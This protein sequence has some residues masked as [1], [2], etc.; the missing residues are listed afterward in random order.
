[1]LLKKI[2][3]KFKKEEETPLVIKQAS[4]KPGS[5][6]LPIITRGYY[7]TNQNTY[8]ADLVSI[9][10]RIVHNGGRKVLYPTVFK[11]LKEVAIQYREQGT[12]PIG[13]LF[14]GHFDI[15]QW[16]RGL[17]EYTMRKLADRDSRTFI[18]QK[19]DSFKPTARTTR[20]LVGETDSL[21][22]YLVD[23][24]PGHWLKLQWAESFNDSGE[25][26]WSKEL[27]IH[28]CG[29]L[30]GG[31]LEATANDILK[32][33]NS[34]LF[35]AIAKREEN[36][37]K[38]SKERAKE[39]KKVIEE[40]QEEVIVF[41]KVLYTFWEAV[42]AEFP[43]ITPA[44]EG[45]GKLAEAWI[46]QEIK[47]GKGIVSN[48]D[49]IN[50]ISPEIYNWINGAYY[51]GFFEVYAHGIIDRPVYE[52]DI[53]SAY[54]SV[55]TELPSLEDCK[56]LYFSED[57][58]DKPSRKELDDYVSRG[59]LVFAGIA[60]LSANTN[61]RVA[62]FPFRLNDQRIIRPRYTEYSK[63]YWKE[64]MYAQKAG[65]LF[66]YEENGVTYPWEIKDVTIILPKDPSNKPLAGLAELYEKRIREGKS[67]VLG[68]VRKTTGNSVYGKMTQSI[69]MPKYAN[70]VIAA[71]TTAEV[72]CKI[73]E[74]IASH[75]DGVNSLVQVATDALF[76]D[77][78]HTG[79]DLTPNKLGAW[80]EV[81]FPNFW[82]TQSGFYG[83]LKGEKDVEDELF[84]HFGETL[85]S[86]GITPK[87]LIEARLTTRDDNGENLLDILW[88][89]REE[90]TWDS[91]IRIPIPKQLSMKSIK[92]ALQEGKFE[93][94]G[95][96]VVGHNGLTEDEAFITTAIG[97]KRTH[98]VWVEEKQWFSGNSPE[99]I[100]YSLINRGNFDSTN[101]EEIIGGLLLDGIGAPAPSFMKLEVEEYGGMTPEE[102]NMTLIMDGAIDPFDEDIVNSMRDYEPYKE[103]INSLKGGDSFED[104]EE[105]EDSLEEYSEKEPE[106]DLEEDE[107]DEGDED[108]S[109]EL[110]EAS[111]YECS[112]AEYRVLRAG[113]Y[114]PI[115]QSS[116]FIE[117]MHT[118]IDPL[119][120]EFYP[121]EDIVEIDGYLYYSKKFLEKLELAFGDIL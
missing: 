2:F 86:R 67:T 30:F 52:Y 107:P 14:Y 33:N 31:S 4:E 60:Y 84:H 119:R 99:K 80:E 91:D 78:P 83:D 115:K 89:F 111:D 37:K 38:T 26:V 18:K 73:L 75:E 101:K 114:D 25:I 42:K 56:A 54:M 55:M 113:R 39:Y 71:A 20:V 102:F 10:G 12:E 5:V 13:Q 121:R 77:A 65:L 106:E 36:F 79:L 11:A 96:F 110:L 3:S 23:W 68:Q 59:A 16:L 46:K 62:P 8:I 34:K 76:F 48:E 88:R 94:A 105:E 87:E 103:Y 19:K 116:L 92:E 44:M 32:V 50:L 64:V 108:P 69:G 22:S 120:I 112:K 72:R 40:T 27:I 28:D 21:N 81:Y 43:D 9:D 97:D 74:A 63:Q 7:S 6:Y 47:K 70:P 1:M 100:H 58:P 51:G 61:K 95:E 118:W 17:D 35:N 93:L 98:P 82:I 104:L 85:R 117:D 45:P 41:K 29:A 57:D 109:E 53:N 15:N 66:D 49:L 24:L 90:K